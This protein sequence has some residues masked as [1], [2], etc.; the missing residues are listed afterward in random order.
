ML[1]KAKTN[2]ATGVKE[3]GTAESGMGVSG[4]ERAIVNGRTDEAFEEE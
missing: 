1:V 3:H 4:R 2:G